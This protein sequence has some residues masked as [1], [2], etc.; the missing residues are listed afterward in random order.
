MVDVDPSLHAKPD[1]PGSSAFRS[2]PTPA[3]LGA[4]LSVE[5]LSVELGGRTILDDVSFTAHAGRIAAVLGPNGAGKSTLF[6][7]LLGLVAPTAGGSHVLGV[8]SN[9][10]SASDRA[11]IA[12]VPETHAEQPSARIDDLEELRTALYPGFDRGVFQSIAADFSLRRDARVRELSRGQ[13]AGLLVALALAQRPALLLLDDPT[14]GLDPLARRRVVDALLAYGRG[15]VG[16]LV[17][18]S[19]E[20]G[21]VERIADDVVVL[22]DGRVRAADGLADLVERTCGVTVSSPA[23]RA[24][25]AAIDGVLRVEQQ[26]DGLSIVVFGTSAA[27]DQT[28]ADVARVA[29]AAIGEPTPISFEECALALLAPRP[30]AEIFS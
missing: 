9:A 8:P 28:L 10:L 27:R 25:I 30:R 2:V 24:A 23:S 21:D 14:L 12:Y 16:T 7:A 18:A 26:R 4:P 29:G 17:F 15:A 5:R 11:R 6:R 20:L 3:S 19:H 13:R 22:T 1:G